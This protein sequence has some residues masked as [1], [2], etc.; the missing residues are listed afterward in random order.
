MS[1]V[2]TPRPP[3]QTVTV[4]R[5]RAPLLWLV[6]GAAVLVIG[7][8][9]WLALSGGGVSIE[10]ETA[11]I[12]Q[13]MT[14]LVAAQNQMDEAAMFEHLSPDAVVL[15]DTQPVIV[16]HAALSQAYANIWP[17]FVSFDL[18]IDKTVVGEAGDIAWQ[19]GTHVYEL[20]IPQVGVTNVPGKWITTLEKI[21]GEWMVT[22]LAVS[23][24]TEA[25]PG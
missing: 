19:Y 14:E 5:R 24:V 7:G 22:A 2:T 20:D 1:T 17:I 16:G 15:I 4:S 6:V 3:Q 21:E 10:D 18:S 23:D 12:E 8:L 9:L 11:E 25:P 13:M